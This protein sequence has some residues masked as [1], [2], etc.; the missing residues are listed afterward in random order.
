MEG[1]SV[2]ERGQKTLSDFS[3]TV[4]AGEVVGVFSTHA[5]VKNDLIR[6]VAGQMGADAGRIY[7]CNEP[8]PFEEKDLVRQRRVGVIHSAQTLIDVLSVAENIFVIRKGVKG[9]VIDGPLLEIQARQLIDEFGMSIAPGTLVRNLSGVERCSLE[10]LKAIALGAQIVAFK[11]LSSFLPD[12][13]IDQLLKFAA[14]LKQRGIGFLLVESSVSTLARYADR[15]VVIKDGRNFWTFAGGG[16]NDETLKTCFSRAREAPLAD[17]SLI[18]SK[19]DVE[20]REVLAFDR[21]NSGVLEALS[22][23][24]RQ[25]EELCILDQEGRG[26][27]ELLAL[28]GGERRPRSGRILVDGS[29]Y[30]A[31]NAWQALDQKIAFVAEN[32]AE[33]MVFRDLS[34]IENLCLPSSRKA[35]GFWLNPKYLSSCLNEYSVFF[36]PGVLDKYPDELS[37]QDLHKLVYCRWHLY[38]PDVVVCIKPYSSV[39]K[40][41]EEIS[42]V[43]I[44]KLLRKGIAVLI[45]TS[46]ASEAESARRKISINQKNVPLLP[47]NDL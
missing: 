15:V 45:L 2:G 6:L 38:K 9:G 11:D 39:D 24:L 26:I 3:L 20:R 19:Q 23:S 34:A 21:V 37:I 14:R 42:A 18:A 17:D 13:E 10:V 31:R 33:S 27:D 43:F 12:V 22:F 7:L 4:Y 16:F 44:D 32:P 35:S 36:E 47:K 40:T 30:T 1:V 46:S 29:D 8:C 25:G 5:T 41:L 28:L